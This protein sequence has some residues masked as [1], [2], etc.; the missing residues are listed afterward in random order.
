MS[1]DCEDDEPRTKKPKKDRQKVQ[2]G[3]YQKVKKS[4]VP[5]NTVENT[6]EPPSNVVYNDKVTIISDIKKMDNIIK[7]HK[8]KGTEY[9]GLL[10]QLLAKLK[11]LYYKKCYIC[12]KNNV[13]DTYAILDCKHYVKNSSV[14]SY[15]SEL[16]SFVDYGYVNF[17]ITVGKQCQ[18]YSKFKR[19]AVP[20]A[21]IKTHISYFV[22]RMNEEQ[23][24]WK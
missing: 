5:E 8:A 16:G 11:V 9:Y 7:Q 18:L 23:D 10:G 19:T 1:D 12:Q 24:F 3:E 22:D 20:I 13:E 14:S 6:V 17:L 15:F 4:I 2:E 21:V